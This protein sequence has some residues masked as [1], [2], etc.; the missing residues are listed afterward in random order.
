VCICG[1]NDAGCVNHASC[2][3]DGVRGRSLLG[4]GGFDGSDGCLGENLESF[5]IC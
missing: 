2:G 5:R 1:V 4:F 3:G